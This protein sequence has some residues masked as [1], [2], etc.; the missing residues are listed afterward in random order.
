MTCAVLLPAVR[1]LLATLRFG[2]TT[3]PPCPV[4]DDSVWSLFVGEPSLCFGLLISERSGSGGSS[5]RPLK[6]ASEESSGV[7][8]CKVPANSGCLSAVGLSEY[9]ATSFWPCEDD[10]G[11]SGDSPCVVN[12]E[13]VNELTKEPRLIAALNLPLRVLVG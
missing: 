6:L 4:D 2:P 1:P 5:N 9:G 11:E 12:R 8:S 13:F 3:E 7:R 10:R